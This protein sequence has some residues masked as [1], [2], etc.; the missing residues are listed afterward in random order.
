MLSLVKIIKTFSKSDKEIC[1]KKLFIT[2]KQQQQHFQA[3]QYHIETQPDR[4]AGIKKKKTE[5]ISSSTP[6]S[7]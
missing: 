1:N 6:L 3:F 2:G 7:E 5:I 4:Q